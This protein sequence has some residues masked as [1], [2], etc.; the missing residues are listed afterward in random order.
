MASYPFLPIVFGHEEQK[1]LLQQAKSIPEIADLATSADEALESA[2][3]QAEKYFEEN[4]ESTAEEAQCTC[5][6]AY[7]TAWAA[8]MSKAHVDGGWRMATADSLTLPSD[9]AAKSLARR[10]AAIVNSHSQEEIIRTRSLYCFVYK[11]AVEALAAPFFHLFSRME[12]W[13]TKGEADFFLVTYN[14]R[15]LEGCFKN[16][17]TLNRIKKV[18]LSQPTMHQQ[19]YPEFYQNMARQEENLKKY[20][21]HVFTLWFEFILEDNS[22]LHI[23]KS[24]RKSEATFRIVPKEMFEGEHDAEGKASGNHQ[25]CWNCSEVFQGT[26]RCARCKVAKYC[27]RECQK[28]HWSEHNKHCKQLERI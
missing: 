24:A 21:E 2:I 27:S 20:D 6:V 14:M 13:K 12:K 17:G 15:E 18:K 11:H 8:L 23:F 19:H 28:A 7:K 22:R 5:F 26:K 9:K 16:L 10:F 4:P 25:L 3:A 1:A